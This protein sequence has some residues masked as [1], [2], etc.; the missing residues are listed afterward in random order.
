MRI[1][2]IEIR[3]DA[4]ARWLTASSD[5]QPAFCIHCGKCLRYG[6]EELDAGLSLGFPLDSDGRVCPTGALSWNDELKIPDIANEKCLLCGACL[7]Q[8]PVKAL[9]LAD[10]KINLNWHSDAAIPPLESFSAARL[11]GSYARPS[12]PL[13]DTI[14]TRIQEQKNQTF[15]PN[16]LARNVLISLGWSATAHKTGVQ[17]SSLDVVGIQ[18]TTCLAAE[19]E[20]DNQ[21]IDIP[22]NLITYVPLLVQRHGW[23]K[24]KIRLL[25]IGMSLPRHR[26][27]YWHVLEDID[28]VLGLHINSASIVYLILCVLLRKPLDLQE[29]ALYLSDSRS[30]RDT[31][32]EF[33]DIPQGHGGILEPL[34]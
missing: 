6:E 2:K 7:A 27:E 30:C 4:C 13:V 14:S 5:A 25:A 12:I 11:C 9:Y 31:P 10:L 32:D 33:E 17:Y 16:I 22:R 24:S 19:V 23:P 15:N 8:C 21:M 18:D 3:P 1:E 29:N 26:E 34:K 28:A 20:L